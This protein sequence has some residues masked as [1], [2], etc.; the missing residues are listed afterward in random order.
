MEEG[1]VDRWMKCFAD[2]QAAAVWIARVTH[3][4]NN[5]PDYP[6]QDS[7]AAR[8]KSE[9]AAAERR[10]S[11]RL[12]SKRLLII[13]KL[14]VMKQKRTPDQ[15]GHTVESIPGGGQRSRWR[16]TVCKAKSGTKAE[17]ESQSCNGD[18][19]QE[20]AEASV[21]DRVKLA[22]CGKRFR[23]GPTRGSDGRRR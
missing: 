17:L 19:K 9:A 3:E 22:K 2:T 8:W 21:V 23:N 12:R 1:E 16:C 10:K 20:W 4:A 13:D 5:Q 7:E 6:F 11:K 15:E 14:K 18:P